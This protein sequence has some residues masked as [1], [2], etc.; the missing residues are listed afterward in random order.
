M[1]RI[2]FE[3]P[4]WILHFGTNEN[5]STSDIRDSLNSNI[6]QQS[7]YLFSDIL[8]HPSQRDSKRKLTFWRPL[9]WPQCWG[10]PWVCRS[11]SSWWTWAILTSFS[12]PLTSCHP[13]E[14]LRCKPR[15]YQGQ[16]FEFMQRALFTFWIHPLQARRSSSAVFTDSW[17][18]QG[19]V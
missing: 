8:W 16:V 19:F 1:L 4:K 3:Y 5:V 2:Q 13:L 18:T 15:L 9:H 6:W 17:N 10:W 12:S 14:G 7:I 11:W